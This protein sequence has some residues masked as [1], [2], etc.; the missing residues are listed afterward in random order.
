MNDPIKAFIIAGE[1]S[2]DY[3]GSRLMAALT[4]IQ[5]KVQFSGIG[6]DKMKKEGLNSLFSI[7]QMAVMGFTEVLKHLPFFI[8]VKKKVLTY[9]KKKCPQFVILI[10][11][12]GFNLHI[13]K[14]IKQQTNTK[15]FYFICPQ[16]WAWKENR[17]KAMKKYIDHAIVIF[18]FEQK[19]YADRD[20]SVYFPG[21]PILDDYKKLVK[22]NY[23]DQHNLSSEK[24]VLTLYPGSRA[25]EFNLHFPI[26]I[27]AAQ[28]VRQQIPELQIILGYSTTLSLNE[29]TNV[30]P[31]DWLTIEYDQ[32]QHALESADAAIVASGT[33]T[34]EAAVFRTP[35][36]VVYK[37]SFIS[38]LIS[39][40]F[41]QVPYAAMAN[42]IAEEE[43]MPELLQDNATPEKISD[44]ILP[45]LEKNETRN[46]VLKK[47]THIK[48]QLGEKGATERTAHYILNNAGLKN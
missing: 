4:A 23:L 5:P 32:P 1:A 10:D 11:Y 46:S 44:K 7:E 17:I 33:S 40:Y 38:W 2:G 35:C 13:A 9:I 34:L 8:Q 28:K 24:P 27:Q 30:S 15:I 21:H 45:L 14:K 29:L 37:M 22:S 36:A 47:L 20:Y 31:P 26:F 48:G 25:Q 43:V 41:V 19:W 39:K 6:G 18:P 3:H 16:I 42:L 12:P